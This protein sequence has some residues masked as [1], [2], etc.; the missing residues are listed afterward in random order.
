MCSK[1]IKQILKNYKS[2]ELHELGLGRGV[3]GT[4]PRPWVNKVS[5]QVREAKMSEDDLSEGDSNLIGTNEGGMLRDYVEEVTS[6]KDQSAKMDL[7]I[8]VLKTPVSVGVGADL[9][10][11][12]TN[13]QKA[14]G[15]RVLNTTIAFQQLF[16]ESDDKLARYV[17]ECSDIKRDE[18]WID[19]LAEMSDHDCTKCFER[20]LGRYNITHYVSAITLG[21]SMFV[22]ETESHYQRTISSH[23]KLEYE[24]IASLEASATFSKKLKRS[25]KDIRYIGK[26]S[27]QD[28]ST[29]E[30]EA[31]IS[32][33]LQPI[34]TLIQNERLR[35]NLEEVLKLYIQKQKQKTGEK[36]NQIQ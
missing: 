8:T 27:K 31:V 35:K 15:R 26:F 23:G 30:K 20:F 5:F 22:V 19:A 32:V 1:P 24:P 36:A 34:T 4:E 17:L 21:A 11:T 33:Q 7:S 29:V 6:I 10:R 13:T 14:I 28:M 25:S 2:W 3:N 9:S 16:D 12:W 18:K